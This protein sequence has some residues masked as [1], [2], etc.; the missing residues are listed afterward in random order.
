MKKLVF[1]AM[2]LT[3]AVTV[4]FAGDSDKREEEKDNRMSIMVGCIATPDT[5]TDV[6]FKPINAPKVDC[7]FSDADM[8]GMVGTELA[9][10]K[11]KVMQA[12]LEQSRVLTQ[13]AYE[14]FRREQQRQKDI[15]KKAQGTKFGR[16]IL[17]ARDKLGA[18]FAEY[19]DQIKV[20]SRID[21]GEAQMEKFLSDAGPAGDLAKS[22]FF[23]KAI[24]CDPKDDSASVNS[25]GGTIT[26][27]TQ[28]LPIIVEIQDLRNETIF[29]KEFAGIKKTSSSSVVSTKGTDFDFDDL[30]TDAFKQAAKAFYEEVTVGLKF[31][32]KAEGV[33][34]VNM[35][36]VTITLDGDEVSADEEIRVSNRCGHEVNVEME[37]FEQKTKPFFT[38][39]KGQ[40]TMTKTIQLKK[41][42]AEKEEKDEDGDDE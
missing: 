8:Q 26:K 27:R 5:R 28:K 34:K 12:K 40:K 25:Y 7:P 29:K 4:S 23:V 42:K 18:A 37:G 38:V 14:E 10:A 3:V 33:K 20:I 15:I 30:M 19:G 41:E 2:V 24:I 22:S 36:D 35:E 16:L 13:I 39:K 11:A 17:I 31:K 32:V 6:M 9:Q 1:G 21:D